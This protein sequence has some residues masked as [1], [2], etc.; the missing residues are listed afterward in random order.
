MADKYI[1]SNITMFNY[2]HKIYLY[3]TN[4]IELELD[5]GTYDEMAEKIAY[6]CFKNNIELVQLHG[7]KLFLTPIA[8]KIYK[9]VDKN[10]N[11]FSKKL[12]VK[13]VIE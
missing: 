8:K 9:E 6:Y 12:N 3:G 7:N 13:V 5:T 2:N 4:G 11:L 1:V 10:K